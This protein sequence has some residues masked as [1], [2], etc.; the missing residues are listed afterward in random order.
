MSKVTIVSA[1]FEIERVDG[2][3]WEEYLKWFDIF[4]KLKVPMLLFVS[5]DVEEFIGNKRKDMDLPTTIVIQDVDEIP[6]YNLKDQIQEVLDS[7]EYKENIS[8]PDRI[9]CKQAMY[10]VIQYSNFPWLKEAAAKN[11]FFFWAV[12]PRNLPKDVPLLVV[13]T[14]GGS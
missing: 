12:A 8:D 13:A 3:P 5:K 14:T 11:H 9:E 7:E 6:Y 2:R 1:L 4:L 10:S